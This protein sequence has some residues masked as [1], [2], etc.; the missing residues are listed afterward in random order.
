MKNFLYVTIVTTV[1]LLLIILGIGKKEYSI[2]DE[3]NNVYL[4]YGEGCQ[5]CKALESYL[6]T[7]PDDVKSTYN[8]VEYEVWNNNQNAQL[9]NKFAEYLND[10]ANGVPYLVIGDKSFIGYSDEYN[11]EI[12]E[13]ITLLNVSNIDIYDLID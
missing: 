9:M 1:V 6:D 7:I 3:L 5:Y 10:E 13:A 11:E 2:N 4:F 12:L 8:L